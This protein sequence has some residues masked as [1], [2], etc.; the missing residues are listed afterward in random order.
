MCDDKISALVIDNDSGMC[1]AKA[2]FAGDD[3]P[4]A[5]KCC[6]SSKVPGKLKFTKTIK[7]SFRMLNKFNYIFQC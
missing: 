4:R 3:A 6:G 2:G 5:F 1:M 7:L